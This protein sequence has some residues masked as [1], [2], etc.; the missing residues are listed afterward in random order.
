M[1]VNRLEKKESIKEIKGLVGDNTSTILV[2]YQGLTVAQIEVLR[3]QMRECNAKMKVIKNTLAK[4]AVAETDNSQLD[5]L[6]SGPT[7]I[8]VSN[9]PVSVAKNLSKFAKDNAKLLFLGGMVDNQFVDVKG[10]K[11]LSE[12]PSKDELRGQIIALISAPATK[13]ARLL[14]TP[15]TQVARVVDAY[16]KK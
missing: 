9:D 10:I 2:H 14:Q 13:L 6:L 3:G 1:V 11:L 7:A 16:A 5:S 15:A 12:M 8:I 4:L